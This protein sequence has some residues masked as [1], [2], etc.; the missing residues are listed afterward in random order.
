MAAIL[1]SMKLNVIASPISCNRQ[2]QKILQ[3]Q[4][5]AIQCLLLLC[6]I[7]CELPKKGGF[8][9]VKGMLVLL[10]ELELC[11]GGASGIGAV[12]ILALPRLA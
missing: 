9:R 7:F 8:H 1:L 4:A 5:L 11:K 2:I 10:L 12:K 3:A 6:K